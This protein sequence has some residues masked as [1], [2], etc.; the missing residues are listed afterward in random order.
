MLCVF[1]QAFEQKVS[2]EFLEA[3]DHFLDAIGAI[4]LVLENHLRQFFQSFFLSLDGLKL[5]DV[6]R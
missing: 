5:I 2:F 1:G 4:F 6:G 3:A